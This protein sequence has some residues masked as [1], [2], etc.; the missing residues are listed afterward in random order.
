MTKVIILNAPPC[1]GKDETAKFLCTA[2]NTRHAE[3]KK[4][5]FELTKAIF[6]VSDEVWDELY[7]REHKEL[8]TDILRGYS[9]RGALI[10]VSESIIKPNFGQDYFGYAAA[11]ELEDGQITVFSDGGFAN[12]LLPIVDKI[13]DE[14]VLVIRIHM[15]GHDFSADSRRYLPDGLVS[16]MIDMTNTYGEFDAFK[17]SVQNEIKK[18]LKQI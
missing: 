7:T 18:F 8:P 15:D 3:F 10:Y 16:N 6:C 9:P 5:L 1:T 4:K 17:R 12:E 13:G 11:S 14:N 2:M